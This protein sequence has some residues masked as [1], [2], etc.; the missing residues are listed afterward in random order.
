MDAPTIA[1]TR[2]GAPD[3][4][5]SLVMLHGIFGRGRNW[6]GIAKALVAARPE[7]ACWL[8]D[9]PFHGD[10]P[11]GAHGDTIHGLATDVRQWLERQ[12]IVPDA[13]LGHSFGGKLALALAARAA[14]DRQLQVWVVDST[15]ALR[16]PSGSA[17]DMLASVRRLPSNFSSRE[18]VVEGLVADG[19]S[20][21]VATWMATNLRRDDNA[22][23]WGLDFDVMT[24][25]MHSFFETDLWSVLDALPPAHTVHFIKASG[26]DAIADDTVR[27]LESPPHPNVHLHHREGGHWIHAE[28]PQAVVELL[29]A[30]L[31]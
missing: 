4:S 23:V 29:A 14:A 25:L 19:W 16:A 10:S 13:I 17:W 2:V 1:S 30:H 28:S 31:E 6:Q 18:Q 27:R 7:Y 5:R 20:R 21:G 11:P 8:V 22:F 15:P 24:R 9:L 26:S 12:T 3:A